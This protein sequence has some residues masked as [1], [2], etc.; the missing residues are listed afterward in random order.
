MGLSRAGYVGVAAAG[1]A[2]LL[3]RALLRKRARKDKPAK[4]D[5][6]AKFAPRSGLTF[7]HRP[8]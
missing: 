7:Y 2:A 4:P 6:A 8:G 5:L 1:A 3:A